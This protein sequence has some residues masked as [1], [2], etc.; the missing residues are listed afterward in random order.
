MI[1]PGRIIGVAKENLEKVV[2]GAL[3]CVLILVGIYLVSRAGGE[4]DAEIGTGFDSREQAQIA[5]KRAIALEELQ[6]AKALYMGL[7]LARPENYYR[8]L[9]E[10]DPFVRVRKVT[11][12]DPAEV[13]VKL[14]EEL[15]AAFRELGYDPEYDAKYHCLIRQSYNMPFKELEEEAIEIEMQRIASARDD[16]LELK[17]L[18]DGLEKCG[19]T[20]V[21]DNGGDDGDGGE[22]TDLVLVGTIKGPRGVEKAWIE[23]RSPDGSG[24]TYILS[25][26]QVIPGWDYRIK[27]IEMNESVLLEKEGEKPVLLRLGP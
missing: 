23:D 22:L 12:K 5:E 16:M 24:D 6:A 18:Q 8:Q 27:E 14:R 19:V 7:L 4:G 21:V 26:G 1:A 3:L 9:V 25:E 11:Y 17:R 10:R 15:L 2:A 20:V 13:L